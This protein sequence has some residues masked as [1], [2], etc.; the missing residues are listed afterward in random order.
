M[1]LC[2][3]YPLMMPGLPV[4]SVIPIKGVAPVKLRTSNLLGVG[5]LRVMAK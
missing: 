3:K 5:V 4:T 2:T 1:G